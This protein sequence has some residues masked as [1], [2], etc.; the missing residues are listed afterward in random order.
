MV[1]SSNIEQ[2]PGASE[3]GEEENLERPG[4]ESEQSIEERKEKIEKR[5]L[6]DGKYTYY[7]VRAAE[8]VREKWRDE[9]LSSEEEDRILEKIEKEYA[10]KLKE[11]AL[12]QDITRD[13][14]GEELKKTVLNKIGGSIDIGSR[15]KIKPRREGDKMGILNRERYFKTV[16]K[17]REETQENNPEWK[18]K[19]DQATY[20]KS[21]DEIGFSK[22]T[23]GFGRAALAEGDLKAAARSYKE[24][25]LRQDSS[26]FG[27]LEDEINQ[28]RNSKNEKL[29]AKAEAAIE[30][31][32]NQS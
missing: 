19:L 25:G 12:S 1:G 23:E 4:K 3:E 2:G 22:H 27:K 7:L 20:G 8:K 11:Q 28:A 32:K 6:A 14:F 18:V 30:I 29:K 9:D 24:A 16:E 13:D 5:A 26:F 10:Q 17:M 15:V 31:L 21:E